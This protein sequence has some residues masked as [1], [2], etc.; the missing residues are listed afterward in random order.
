VPALTTT[1]VS[2]V[3]PDLKHDPLSSEH[4]HGR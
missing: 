4:A 1:T 3:A 2:F